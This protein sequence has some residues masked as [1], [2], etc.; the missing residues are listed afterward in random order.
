MGM[1]SEAVSHPPGASAA[2]GSRSVFLSYASA[3]AQIANQVCEYLESHGVSCWM[4][5]RDVKP[6]AVYADAI[7]RAI[8]EASALVLVLSG[9]AM[10][11]EHVSREVERAGS[12]HKQIIAL[13]IDATALSAELEYFLSRSQWID[14][15]ALGM[16]AALARLAEAVGQGSRASATDLASSSGSDSGGPAVS[17]AVGTANVARRVIFAAAVVVVLGIAGTLATHFWPTKHPE[18]QAPAV[19]AISDKSIAVLPFA[20]MSERKDQEYFSDGM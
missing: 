11:S 1:S 7:V 5:P 6:G 4:A 17:R 13:K 2:A 14:V 12:K 3:D 8:N 18:A 9:A 20:D 10:A 19:A 15:L 16:P